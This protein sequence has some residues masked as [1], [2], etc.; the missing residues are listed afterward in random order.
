MRL[1]N[2]A[3]KVKGTVAGTYRTVLVAHSEFFNRP[4][5][6]K[7]NKVQ[8]TNKKCA[9]DRAYLG[10]LQKSQPEMLAGR[11]SS[12]GFGED[13]WCS[14]DSSSASDCASSISPLFTIDD[15]GNAHLDPFRT[16]PS[17]LS[18]ECISEVLTYCAFHPEVQH[19]YNYMPL[20]LYRSNKRDVAQTIPWLHPQ[21]H[22]I[23]SSLDVFCNELPTIVQCL[24]SLGRIT[25]P[26][27][28]IGQQSKYDFLK[29]S[30][31]RKACYAAG[32]YR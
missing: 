16:Y 14:Q 29:E 6:V 20:T 30:N 1:V 11:C 31:L 7:A 23:Y 17:E 25:S 27:S 3:E 5:S 21:G 12:T 26:A 22:A 13:A 32:S 4:K 2:S 8:R 15:Y 10:L 28:C 9:Y 18:P 24:A 19:S